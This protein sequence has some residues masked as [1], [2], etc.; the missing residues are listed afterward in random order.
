[1]TPSRHLRRSLLA[2]PALLFL[3]AAAP[4]ASTALPAAAAPEPSPVPKR[5]QLEIAPG[6]LRIAV[7]NT[8]EGPR[9]FFYLTSKVTNNGASDLLFAP[10]F[11]LATDETSEPLRSGRDIPIA[12]TRAIMERLSNQFLEDQIS[13]VGNIL[14]GPENARESLAIW[15]VPHMR[16]SELAIY[17]SGFSGETITLD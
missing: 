16:L 10:T 12:V 17:A 6:P 15:P 1:M 8:A 2:L 13:V 4:F 3:V 11:E 7:V 14:R 5:W 9:A